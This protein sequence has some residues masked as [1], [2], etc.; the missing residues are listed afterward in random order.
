M[1]WLKLT[2]AYIKGPSYLVT[3]YVNAEQISFMEPAEESDSYRAGTWL[4]FAGDS[5]KVLRVIE[6]QDEILEMIR[7]G[8]VREARLYSSTD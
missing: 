7:K 3:A 2:K 6:T 1:I 8:A 5:E 4:E